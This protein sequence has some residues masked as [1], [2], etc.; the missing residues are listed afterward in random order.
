MTE[1][2]INLQQKKVTFVPTIK[3]VTSVREDHQIPTVTIVIAKSLLAIRD[4]GT[5]SKGRNSRTK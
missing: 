2:S 4:A 3:E 1:F 5:Q